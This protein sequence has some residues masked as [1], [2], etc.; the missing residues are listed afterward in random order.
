MRAES[1]AVPRLWASMVDCA[2]IEILLRQRL[3]NMIRE[4]G[5]A[6]IDRA[7]LRC[8]AHFSDVQPRRILMQMLNVLNLLTAVHGDGRR[9]IFV[10]KF[11]LIVADDHHGLRACHL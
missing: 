8:V 5:R 11:T 4:F 10:E 6:R 9:Q 2:K 1:Q 7:L 3:Q